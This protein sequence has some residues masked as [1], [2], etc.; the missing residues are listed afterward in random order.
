MT[1]THIKF[2]IYIGFNSFTYTKKWSGLGKVGHFKQIGGD[3]PLRNLC[4]L[5]RRLK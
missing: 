5:P 3:Q 1:D 4:N 2:S